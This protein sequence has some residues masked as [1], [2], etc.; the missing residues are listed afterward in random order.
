[1]DK[2]PSAEEQHLRSLPLD[3]YALWMLESGKYGVNPTTGEVRNTRTGRYVGS[4][5]KQGYRVVG[6]CYNRRLVRQVK[7]HRLIALRL[8]GSAALDGRQVGHLDQVKTNN[9]GENL[10]VPASAADHVRFDGTDKNLTYRTP[11]KVSWPPCYRCNNNGG[12]ITPPSRTPDRISGSRFGLAGILCG[13][14]YRTLQERER[15]REG[16]AV[17]KRTN[18]TGRRHGEVLAAVVSGRE[19]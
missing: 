2:T 7:V 12:V 6:L 10:W 11:V 15:R 3:D 4:A 19:P 8:H 16:K 17:D 9:K 14:C 13:R 5:N 1:M 18:R